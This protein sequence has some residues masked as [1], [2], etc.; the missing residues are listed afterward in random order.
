MVSEDEVS[1]VDS[2]GQFPPKLVLN[3]NLGQNC[4]THW[5]A[6]APAHYLSISQQCCQLDQADGP[7][8]HSSAPW[9][10][11]H[12]TIKQD[13]PFLSG[14][15]YRY[16]LIRLQVRFYICLERLSVTSISPSTSYVSTTWISQ[17][18]LI[19]YWQ[20]GH[21]VCVVKLSHVE[22][23]SVHLSVQPSLS[24]KLKLDTLPTLVRYQGCLNM[25][26][27]SH[28]TYLITIKVL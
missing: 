15:K 14:Q 12:W 24:C 28:F 19:G 4:E 17:R 26:T 20:Q 5:C 21:R 10:C 2:L 18:N 22:T 23:K 27:T 8:A 3:T 6:S 1:D 13:I 9:Y 16:T 25:K 11:N 7:S